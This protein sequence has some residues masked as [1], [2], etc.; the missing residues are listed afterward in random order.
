MSITVE[1]FMETVSDYKVNLVAGKDGIGNIIE[2]FQIVENNLAMTHVNNNELVFCS[3]EDMN[4]EAVFVRFIEELIARQS[5]G[6]VIMQGHYLT[7]ISDVVKNLCNIQR[8]PLMVLASSVNMST[9]TKLLSIQ[10]LESEKINRQLF[11]AMKNAISFP[12]KLDGYVPTL[13]QSGFKKNE[14]YA[15]SIVK[16]KHRELITSSESQWLVKSME[17]Q[18]LKAGDKSFVLTM[19]DIYVF[20]FSNYSEEEMR[21]IMLKMIMLLRMKEYQ[22]Y[23]GSSINHSDV[24]QLTNA[25][26]QAK[27]VVNLSERNGWENQLVQYR[28]LD[29]Y[30]LLLAIDDKNTMKQYY[31]AKLGVL[32]KHD[33]NNGSDYLEFLKVYLNSNCNINDTADKLFIHRNTVVYKIKKINEL[34][35][36]DLS[37][38][39]VRVKLFLAI[40]LQNII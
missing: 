14:P 10:L 9:I 26:V 16:M 6:L 15:V 39:E 33:Q 12:K 4:D 3:G 7:E 27:K 20:V 40:M 38:L 18:L 32:E 2:W 1:R 5:S 17:A 21:E 34:L 29:I 22:F 23:V 24:E 25:Y 11:S 31:D 37:E 36:C 8:F 19:D 35:D 13:V 30:Q 28:E